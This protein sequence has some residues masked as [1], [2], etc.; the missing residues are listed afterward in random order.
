M[1]AKS[2]VG[3]K[4]SGC[5]WAPVRLR[6]I[7]SSRLVDVSSGPDT[8]LD[9]HEPF[10]ALL[11]RVQRRQLSGV[12]EVYA[13]GA[14]S[15]VY[16]N[17]GLPVFAEEGTVSESLGTM[18]VRE[19][20]LSAQQYTKVLEC[21]TNSVMDSEQQRFGQ[22]A[23][24]LGFLTDEQVADALQMQV[25]LKI[26]RCIEWDSPVCEFRPAP[27]EV[28]SVRHFPCLIEPLVVEGIRNSYTLERIRRL[29]GQRTE[30]C[31]VLAQPIPILAGQFALRARERALLGRIDGST[32]FSG[33]LNQVADETLLL[34]QLLCALQAT[35]RLLWRTDKPLNEQL[36]PSP[37]EASSLPV[38]HQAAALGS[39][40]S[41][42]A[43][44]AELGAFTQRPAPA[45][46]TELPSLTQ[47]SPVATSIELRAL[48]QRPAPAAGT[49]L[50]SLAQQS[51]VATSIELRALAQR[52]APAAGTELPSLAQQS[53]V[54]TS[55]EL[56]AL[57]QRP[58]PAA[59][60][61]PPARVHHPAPAARTELPALAQRPAPVAGTELPAP[62]HRPVPTAK[63]EL[64]SLALRPAPAADTEPPGRVHHPAPA[65]DARPSSSHVGTSET[66]LEHRRQRLVAQLGHAQAG[67]DPANAL[68]DQAALH[69]RVVVPR[70]PVPA[71][72]DRLRAETAFLSGKRL[73]DAQDY[74]A[75]HEAFSEA[76]RLHPLAVEY[77][78]HA[79]WA[80]FNTLKKPGEK[81]LK[82]KDLRSLA[83]QALQQNR[84]MAFA[85][86][87]LGKL[88]LLDGD[89]A[90]A[91]MEFRMAA[92]LEPRNSEYRRAEQSIKTE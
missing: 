22:L 9:Q 80:L 61:E 82:R 34:A 64:L 17:A 77:S 13:H 68:D 7:V 43:A 29:C 12:L 54:A 16:V 42:R 46:G 81:L 36:M 47:Q 79:E 3:R 55:T 89:Q 25:R 67:P 63:I 4:D 30:E 87:V 45:A 71:R 48:A 84:G 19:G 78:L 52:P 59:D 44:G 75:A 56:R 15:L 51:P 5:T 53:P 39:H 14:F 35:G 58:T 31:P 62:V 24:A 90:S 32:T 6:A 50:P 23:I 28:D 27:D 66:A 92:Q 70:P 60:T 38:A 72:Q 26:V 83:L 73:L 57:A 65:A 41:I 88:D 1:A 8:A 10:L 49:E 33:L 11:M 37:G 86:F 91:R 2:G 76:R 40:E 20:Q 69:Q 18:L 74:P 85:H 21:M